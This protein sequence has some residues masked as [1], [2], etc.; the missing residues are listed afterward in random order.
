[1]LLSN[2]DRMWKNLYVW[3]SVTVLTEKV[4]RVVLLI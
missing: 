1:M 2:Q 3:I 4:V